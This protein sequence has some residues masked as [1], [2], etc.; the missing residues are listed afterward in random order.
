MRDC[1]VPHD[2]VH[3][4]I[5]CLIQWETSC[6]LLRFAMILYQVNQLVCVMLCMQFNYLFDIQWLIQQYPE[7]KRSE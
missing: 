3:M 1:C 4:Q 2:F 6:A 5:Y 7:K